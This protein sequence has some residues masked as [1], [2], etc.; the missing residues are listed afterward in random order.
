M[1]T[2]NGILESLSALVDSP[3]FSH[4]SL[5]AVQSAPVSFPSHGDLQEALLVAGLHSTLKK[6]NLA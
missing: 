4:G 3:R 1:L 5:M 2:T 6:L